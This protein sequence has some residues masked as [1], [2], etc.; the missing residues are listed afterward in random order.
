MRH[1][2]Q[3]GCTGFWGLSCGL[4]TRSATAGQT[5]H[6]SYCTAILRPR[7]WPARSRK[8]WSR[9]RVSARSSDGQ[10]T[11]KGNSLQPTRLVT[12]AE[13]RSGSR[14]FVRRWARHPVGM[15]CVLARPCTRLDSPGVFPESN[16]LLWYYWL[17]C[18]C[19]FHNHCVKHRVSCFAFCR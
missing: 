7:Q 17:G 4:T 11:N 13:V 12:T 19:G 8:H 1:S 9:C 10:E 14:R 6:R 18:A 15:K 3:A 16:L 2:G 5:C